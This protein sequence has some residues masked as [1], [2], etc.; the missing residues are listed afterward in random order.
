M[1]GRTGQLHWR[2][3]LAV[4]MRSTPSSRVP[5][6]LGL[7]QDHAARRF[8]RLPDLRRRIHREVAPLDRLTEGVL[9]PGQVL[10]RGGRG[11]LAAPLRIPAGDRFRLEG[12]AAPARRTAGAGSCRGSTSACAPPTKARASAPPPASNAHRRRSGRAAPRRGSPRSPPAPGARRGARASASP[13][14]C[15]A[16]PWDVAGGAGRVLESPGASASSAR[17]RRCRR[18][19]CVWGVASSCPRFRCR[20]LRLPSS[21]SPSSRGG[22]AP[23]SVAGPWPTP[24][25]RASSNSARASRRRRAG[26]TPGPR[27]AG[28]SERGARARGT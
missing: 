24:R 7:E 21:S 27:S 2:P 25:S 26:R 13:S 12:S 15:R 28:K 23:P 5:P 18:G 6:D 17:S 11:D 19:G 8:L 3:S 9:E 20:L 14:P 4:T 1:R 16:T 22:A 10:V